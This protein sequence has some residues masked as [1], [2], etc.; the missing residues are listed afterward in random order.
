MTP[1]YPADWDDKYTDPQLRLRLKDEVVAGDKGGKPGQWSARKAQLL[2]AEYEKAGGGYRGEKDE[3]Q[4]HLT[5]WTDERWQ[6]ADGSADAR[7]G[8]PQE[9]GGASRRYLPE[10][11]WEQLSEEEK[12]ATD[13]EKAAGSARGEQFVPNTD[14]A[15][16]AGHDARQHHP[17]PGDADA[18][19]LEGYDDLDAR[20]AAKEVAALDD[21]DQ[22]RAVRDHERA[23]KNRKTVLDR[24]ERE[25]S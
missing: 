20:Q 12:R 6:T 1:G 19:P 14:A 22:V 4:Q 16:E 25:L 3:S 11:A 9:R 21:D 5:A 10:K 13:A 8:G 23:H 17:Q 7:T 18:P 24:V 15:A 2:A